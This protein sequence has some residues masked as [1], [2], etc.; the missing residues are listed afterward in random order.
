MQVSPDPA[1]LL[2]LLKEYQAPLSVIK[3]ASITALP[4]AGGASA[5]GDS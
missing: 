2:Q 3:S 5:G 1:Q 4:A